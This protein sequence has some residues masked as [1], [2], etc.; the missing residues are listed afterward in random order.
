MRVILS[1]AKDH[2]YEDWITQKTENV[3]SAYARSLA[4][5]GMT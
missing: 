2:T 3:S 4:P 5:F 1:E